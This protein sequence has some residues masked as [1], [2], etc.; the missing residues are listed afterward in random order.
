MD[1][2]DI[3]PILRQ[4]LIDAGFDEYDLADD[5]V[6]MDITGKVFGILSAPLVEQMDLIETG[7][8]IDNYNEMTTDQMDALVANVFL[9]R[10]EGAKAKA[11]VTVYFTS[12]QTV[13]VDAEE[14][15]FYTKEGLKF[16]PQTDYSFY[17]YQM[18]TESIQGVTYY[19]VKIP[20]IAEEVGDSY[21]VQAGTIVYSNLSIPFYSHVN[22]KLPASGGINEETNT[23][24]KTSAMR[25][26][27][28]RDNVMK[29][30][31]WTVFMQRYG[32]LIDLYTVG[33]LDPEMQRD[34]CRASWC[35]F[36]HRG[37]MSDPYVKNKLQYVTNEVVAVDVDTDES[38]V[39]FKLPTER[40]HNDIIVYDSGA[41]DDGNGSDLYKIRIRGDVR[42]QNDWMPFSSA[43]PTADGEISSFV[44]PTVVYGLKIEYGGSELDVVAMEV[45]NIHHRYSMREAIDYY[46]VIPEYDGGAIEVSFY[47]NESISAY[48]DDIVQ[49]S[50]RPIVADTLF[51]NF[52]PIV[53]EN[54]KITYVD[55]SMSPVVEKTVREAISDYL[56]YYSGTDPIYVSEIIKLVQDATGIKMPEIGERDSSP[57]ITQDTIDTS[58][59][60]IE[61]AQY[62]I[63]GTVI[64]TKSTQ[65]LAPVRDD[66]ISASNNTCRYYLGDDFLELVKG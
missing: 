18:T 14:S 36:G 32:D 11:T 52:I 21:E 54:L 22:N 50:E 27:A 48:Q 47:K 26:V 9:K 16:Y 19:V 3:I 29:D 8:S 66:L 44:E 33:F 49:D 46:V 10:R 24:L 13:N 2:R 42:Y 35:W 51:K 6:L 64:R 55:N 57:D 43:Y 25:A 5:T 45:I 39:E 56:F 12:Q 63:D 7:Q 17:P 60:V 58:P 15:Y 59:F 62:N 40:D 61:Y 28:T 37:G 20:V 38:L 1:R 41:Y 34:V 31:L 23:D 30:S 4:R 65:I 53:I